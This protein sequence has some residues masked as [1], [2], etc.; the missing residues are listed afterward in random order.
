MSNPRYEALR[1]MH[2]RALVEGRVVGMVF[3]PALVTRIQS[4]PEGHTLAVDTPFEACSSSC[5]RPAARCT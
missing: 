1:W 3:G 2:E 5:R 4:S